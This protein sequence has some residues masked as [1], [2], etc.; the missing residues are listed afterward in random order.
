MEMYPDLSLTRRH[1]APPN[2][3]TNITLCHIEL[4]VEQPTPLHERGIK[5][6]ECIRR[7]SRVVSQSVFPGKAWLHNDVARDL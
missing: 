2:T 1:L 4:G 6:Y 7:P 3:N 5:L